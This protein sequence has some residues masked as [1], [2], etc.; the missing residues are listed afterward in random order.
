MKAAYWIPAIS[1]LKESYNIFTNREMAW[2]LL[3][4]AQ[5]APR[6]LH[7]LTGNPILEG[8]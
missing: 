3:S 5:Q 7:V 1:K 4:P 6:A 8:T 2:E